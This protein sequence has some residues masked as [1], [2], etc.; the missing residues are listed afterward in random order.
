MT[1]MLRLYGWLEDG[2]IRPPTTHHGVNAGDSLQASGARRRMMRSPGSVD[3]H[4]NERTDA[5]QPSV[6][7]I[8]AERLLISD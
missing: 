4:T 8:P 1:L 3:E 2:R 6:I 5:A 7:G